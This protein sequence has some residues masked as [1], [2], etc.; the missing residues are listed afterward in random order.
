MA[1]IQTHVV[2]RETIVTLQDIEHWADHINPDNTG[3]G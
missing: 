2:L 1:N 3:R